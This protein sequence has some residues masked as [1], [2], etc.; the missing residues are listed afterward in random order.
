MKRN[1]TQTVLV[2]LALTLLA[3]SAL[4]A[5]APAD[6]CKFQR[7]IDKGG[8]SISIDIPADEPCG[9]G[10]FFL[11]IVPKKGDPQA[12]K[13]DRDGML[14]DAMVVEL[15]GAAPAEIVVIEKGTDALA[16]GAITIFESIDGHYAE[17]R[18]ARL[19]V[20]AAAGYAGR[21][22]F[23]VKD[24]VIEREFPVY[25]PSAEPGGE[26]QPTGETRKLKYDFAG[27]K[28]VAR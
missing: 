23:V 15:S 13:V 11:T 1:P 21:D 4:A 24:G 5:K 27:D 6:P 20:D 9:L 14:T 19:A 3:G 18:V 10:T 16:L 8:I 2:L 26:P 25:A 17:R 22:L 12:L 28:W 7:T